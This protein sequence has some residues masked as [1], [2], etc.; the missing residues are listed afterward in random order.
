MGIEYGWAWT[1]TLGIIIVILAILVVR[2]NSHPRCKWC[3]SRNTRRRTNSVLHIDD[4]LC[5]L[6]VVHCTFCDVC[7][8]SSNIVVKR[9]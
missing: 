9:L 7:G 8:S 4:G 6:D 3:K 1:L 2:H 5:V